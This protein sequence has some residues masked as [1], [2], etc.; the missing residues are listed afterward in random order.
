MGKKSNIDS[1]LQCLSEVISEDYFHDLFTELIECSE[2]LEEVKQIE[3]LEILGDKFEKFYNIDELME[4]EKKFISDQ[5]IKCTHFSNLSRICEL[6]ALMFSFVDKRYCEFLRVS[7]KTEELTLDVRKE[8]AESV[9][10]FEEAYF[11]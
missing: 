3:L 2:Y 7:L 6:T 9:E 4:N 8:I 5:L 11:K 10:E 1:K